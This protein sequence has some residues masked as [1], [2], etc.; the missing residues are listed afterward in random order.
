MIAVAPLESR[1]DKRSQVGVDAVLRYAFIRT[2]ATAALVCLSSGCNSR[3]HVI[4]ST[5]PTGPSSVVDAP[6]VPA[7]VLVSVTVDPSAVFSGGSVAGRVQLS[8]PAPAQGVTVA[9]SASNPAVSVP[10]TITVPAGAES[11]SFVVTTRPLESEITVSIAASATNRFTQTSL[12]LWIRTPPYIATWVDPGNGQRISAQRLT[13]PSVHR[14]QCY[15]NT[16]AVGAFAT[17]LSY[18]LAFSARQGAPLVAGTYENAQSG[19]AF[20][21]DPSLPL[22]DVSA[23]G[24]SSCSRPSLSR[25]GVSQVEVVP[26]RIGTVRR[27]IAAFEQQ[28]GVVTI[29]GEVAAVDVP[30][31][32]TSGDRCIVP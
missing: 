9:L 8:F 31:T 14:A 7:S 23:S 2:V 11:A 15:G 24:F 26:D 3:T 29:R 32:N 16:I 20:P 25:F 4:D 30:P 17:S 1:V 27:F 10:A 12:A 21:R 18:S 22:L 19:F 13:G 6:P 28:C 5:T